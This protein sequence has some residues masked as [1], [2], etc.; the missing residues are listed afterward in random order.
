MTMNWHLGWFS[1]YFTDLL[2]MP[3]VLSMLW[4]I[5]LKIQKSKTFLPWYFISIVFIT[6]SYTFEVYLPKIDQAYTADYWD[7]FYY[8]IGAI[9]FYFYQRKLLQQ[10]LI[11]KLK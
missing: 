10:Q 6:W 2:C 7:V 4:F 11:F 1:N 3:I 8:L 5:L 9:S